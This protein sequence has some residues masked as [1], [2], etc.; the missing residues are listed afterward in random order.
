MIVLPGP[1]VLA[2]VLGLFVLSLEYEWAARHF[3]RLRD[4]AIGGAHL[5]AANLVG[6]VLSLL[7]AV[8]MIAGGIVWALNDNLPMSSWFTG[9]TLSGGGVL[10]LGTI[11]WSVLDLRR[12]RRATGAAGTS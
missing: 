11:I 6:T 3:D 9:G 12:H 10:A 2:I 4:K 1:G 8:G 5:A 7:A